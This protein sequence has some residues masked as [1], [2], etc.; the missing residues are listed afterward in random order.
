MRLCLLWIHNAI[1]ILTG[2]DD[3]AFRFFLLIKTKNAE[4]RLGQLLHCFVLS[5][6][7][8]LGLCPAPNT[9]QTVRDAITQNL[10]V[11][12]MIQRLTGS[13][14][15]FEDVELRQRYRYHPLFGAYARQRPKL[16]KRPV[17]TKILEKVNTLGYIPLFEWNYL[18]QIDWSQFPECFSTK[19]LIERLKYIANPRQMDIEKE[20][21]EFITAA[22]ERY[23]T[24]ITVPKSC[25]IE[26]SI[27]CFEAL[28]AKL[29]VL[30]RP[31]EVLDDVNKD[32]AKTL[33][34]LDLVVPPNQS[35]TM[36]HPSREQKP[37]SFHKV[38]VPFCVLP[39]QAPDTDCESFLR[40]RRNS[41]RHHDATKAQPP[42]EK[43]MATR[44]LL[45]IG[46][47]ERKPNPAKSE[48][49]PR[50]L[51][52]Q[53]I[54]LAARS[55]ISYLEFKVLHAEKKVERPRQNCFA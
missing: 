48:A 14:D 7:I 9:P 45:K 4:M 3:S 33:Q 18:L 1:V 27:K 26:Q 16:L 24:A 10:E 8:L 51:K 52:L 44:R 28:K 35:K 55:R 11:L 49:D 22:N 25:T 32:V 6:A 12:F 46:K 13:V 20:T 19:S 38:N 23:K 17:V 42:A 29:P 15:S 21:T 50:L 43:P 40:F 5:F 41:L 37:N 54:I 47:T 30:Q 39:A 2:V 53:R 34:K 36:S 31:E